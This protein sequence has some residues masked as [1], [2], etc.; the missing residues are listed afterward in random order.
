MANKRLNAVISIGGA[1]SSSLGSAIGSV[2]S[3][4][5]ALGESVRG[6]AAR[7]RQL[8][9]SVQT[10]GRM[11]KDV[12][13]LRTRY[14]AVTRE[15]ERQRAILQQTISLEARRK[16]NSAR[17]TE[18][19]GALRSTVVGGTVAASPFLVAMKGA[20][21]FEYK[22][23]LI[24][25]TANMTS[26]EIARL[27]ADI[28]AS[29]KA[30]NQSATSTQSAI[31]FLIAAGM[32]LG[33]ARQLMTPVGKTATATGGEVEDMAKAVFTLNDSLK[34]KPGDMMAAMD[35]LATAGKEGNVELKDMAKQLPVLASGFVALK[36]EGRE[37]AA[38]IGAALQIARKGTDTAEKAATNME[39]YIAKIMSPETLKKAKKNFNL[40]LYKIIQDAQK[41]GANPFEKSF[42]AIMKATKGDQKLIGDLFQD[43]QVQSFLRPMIQN[44]DKYLEIKA[45]ALK[46]DGAVDSDFAKIMATTKEQLDQVGGAIGRFS[47]E[48]GAALTKGF[49]GP[50][51]LAENI[52][53][54]TRWIG[55]NRELVG[56]I[57][58]VSVALLGTAVAVRTV[59]MGV[60][61]AKGAWFLY[62]G[63]LLAVGA[64]GPISAAG[65]TVAGTA[66]AG[67]AAGATAGA[68]AFRALGLAMKGAGVLAAGAFA[69]FE[70]F[71]LGAASYDLWKAKNREGVTLT[72][73]AQRRIANGEAGST[74]PKP[75]AMGSGSVDLSASLPQPAMATGKGAA[76][77][78]QDNSQHTYQITQ[79][80]GQSTRALA[81]EIERIQRQKSAVKS[82]SLMFDGAGS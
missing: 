38:T 23:Q 30:T 18:V 12:D 26:A 59:Q 73:E 2:Q 69:G 43:M 34:I 17:R 8:G 14:A 25:N 72:P 66:A 62:R 76:P 80:P 68:S 74:A 3:R 60:T 79:Q 24:G 56:T 53:G 55:A 46:G 57:A 1:V 48:L 64:A 49:G 47:I 21:E 33:T 41:K 42:E 36:M 51:G 9:E 54:V 75:G 16:A 37:A 77:V 81:E 13:G 28:M 15:L 6:L 35:T 5:G 61:I 40:D 29:S 11:G 27:S 67:S 45:K 52:D 65:S 70:L 50:G 32:E 71:K 10:F 7:Q 4:I 63:A 22:L 19:G 20:S 44:Y 31:G 58:K 78:I 39:N 82:R